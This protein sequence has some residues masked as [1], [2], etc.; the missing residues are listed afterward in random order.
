[1]REGLADS[2]QVLL[3]GGAYP[4]RPLENQTKTLREIAEQFRLA[5]RPPSP[6][7]LIASVAAALLPSHLLSVRRES[8]ARPASAQPVSCDTDSQHG[9]NS[10]LSGNSLNANNDSHARVG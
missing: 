10:V 1:V 7:T 6:R 5:G 2:R 3:G 9:K 4:N 8:L